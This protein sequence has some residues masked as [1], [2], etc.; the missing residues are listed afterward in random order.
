MLVLGVLTALGPLSIDAYLPALPTIEADLRALSGAGAI[1]LSAYFLGLAGTQ[2]PFGA[3]A[4][5]IGRRPPLIGGLLLY[6]LGSVGCALRPRC[7]SSRWRGWHR[8]SGPRR[9][10]W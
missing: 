4:D 3:L 6:V 9:A 2:L 5:R 10:W 7:R 8:G 1:T